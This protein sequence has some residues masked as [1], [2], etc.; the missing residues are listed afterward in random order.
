MKHWPFL[1]FL[2]AAPVHADITHR[3]QSS[4]SLNVDGAAS[5]AQRIGSSYSLSG[6]NIT[7]T[8]DSSAGAI[9][10]LN[11]ATAGV[12]SGVPTSL[13]TTFAVT[14]AGDAFTFAESLTVADTIPSAT[15]TTNGVAPLPAFGI[16]TTTAGGTAGSLAGGIASDHAITNLAGGGPGTQAVGQVITELTIK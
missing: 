4:V 2:L 9:G 6:T 13:E 11:T 16:V 1:L 12:S 15:S 5:A 8:Y 3:I 14:T 10:G 7:P